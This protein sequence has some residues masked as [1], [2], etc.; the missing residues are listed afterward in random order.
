MPVSSVQWQP[1]EY[2]AFASSVANQVAQRLSPHEALVAGVVARFTED[3]SRLAAGS[4]EVGRVGQCEQW[5]CFPAEELWWPV[6]WCPYQAVSTASV[7]WSLQ[8]A[9]GADAPPTTG[10]AGSAAGTVTSAEA[11]L[12]RM[13]SGV[14]EDRAVSQTV[15]VHAAGGS[16]EEAAASQCTQGPPSPAG[17]TR[18]AK[19]THRR[20]ARRKVGRGC[21]A[22]HEPGSDSELTER[23]EPT[24]LDGELEGVAEACVHAANGLV[25]HADPGDGAAVVG[26]CCPCLQSDPSHQHAECCSS[27]PGGR[28]SQD[29]SEP[30]G[31]QD[32]NSSVLGFLTHAD[33]GSVKQTARH[34]CPGLKVSTSGSHVARTAALQELLGWAFVDGLQ[35]VEGWLDFDQVGEDLDALES[36]VWVGAL[37]CRRP[38]GCKSPLR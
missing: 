19:T 34:L 14:A 11:A 9:R 31:I 33:W 23:S 28:S 29:S 4:D 1:G 26:L 8:T 35:E 25:C 30:E 13:D 38:V 15:L 22:L 36:D 17:Q 18:A 27:H 3:L 20:R 21:A 7:D 24:S 5:Q 12:L 2:I 32:I 16:V 6:W 10:C 37:L